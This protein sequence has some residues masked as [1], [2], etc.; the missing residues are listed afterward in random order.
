MCCQYD[1]WGSGILMSSF[2]D[3]F[4]H[5]P[6]LSKSTSSASLGASALVKCVVMA[7]AKGCWG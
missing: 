3:A 7:W 2:V 6:G 4:W 1:C 5:D